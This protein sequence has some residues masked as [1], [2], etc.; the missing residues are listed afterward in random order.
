MS[1]RDFA[2]LIGVSS[3]I[4]SLGFLIFVIRENSLAIEQQA[5]LERANTIAAP[6][7]ES[8]LASILV[9]V[10]KVDGDFGLPARF[11]DRYDLTIEEAILWERHLWH[12]WEAIEA[13]Y[14]TEGASEKLERQIRL[15]LL[16]HS[17]SMYVD[18]A[19][20]YQ[21]NEDFGT[22]IRRVQSTQAEVLDAL[23]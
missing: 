4:V 1:P 9:K 17:N 8:E 12:V 7:F 14:I 6:Y 18:N 13:S 22:Y 10:S 2:E 5:A 16:S 23:E 19:L 15:L 3:I 20:K 11:V 21:F